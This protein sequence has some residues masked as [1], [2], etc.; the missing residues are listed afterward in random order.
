MKV[1]GIIAEYNPFH[2]GHKY[3]IEEARRLTDADCIV[4][5]MSGPFTQRGLPACYDKWSRA[6]MAVESGAD[7]VIE[8]PFIYACNSGME[9]AQGA[10][11]ILDSLGCIDYIAF[12]AESDDAELIFRTANACA[13]KEGLLPQY[14][15][16]YLSEGM[17]YGRAFS[18][19]VGEA[20]GEE[21]R[22]VL[23]SPNNLLGV[24][25][26]KSLILRD[27]DIKAVPVLRKGSDHNDLTVA[28]EIF[29]SGTAV[30]EMLDI[31]DFEKVS[32]Y[33][34]SSALK[35]GDASSHRNSKE[36]KDN[37]FD[38]LKYKISTTSAER[39]SEIYSVEEGIENRIK[40]IMTEGSGETDFDS[41]IMEIKNK[42]F[43]YARLQ[44]IMSYILMDLT[45]KEFQDL[46]G[47]YYGRVL[48]F[49]STGAK[50]LKSMAEPS[51]IPIFTNIGQ[52]SDC[53]RKIARCL[54]I[55]ARASDLFSMVYGDG[56][57]GQDKKQI[58]Y[59]LG[60]YGR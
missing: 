45:D 55:D 36:V 46:K 29:A 24:E 35:I 8:L 14:I 51:R 39:L 44:R 23:D 53:D 5:V 54:E 57:I 33:I 7:L 48:G 41:F 56:R 28:S 16:K 13:D 31:G 12:G 3:H 49:S 34:P 15:K 22:A 42:R 9:F 2:N 10:C 25:Y 32:K 43:T 19:A 27:S 17:T 11:G 40:K 21:L 18:T 47:T 20:Y 26:I 58:P 6:A 59:I 60:M 30:R 38:L 52:A 1:T 37:M 4:A 50:L